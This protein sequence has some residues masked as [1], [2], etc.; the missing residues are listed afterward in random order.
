MIVF[1]LIFA[2]IAFL[3][4]KG[5]WRNISCASP[6]PQDNGPIGYPT[7]WSALDKRQVIRLL[8]GG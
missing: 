7:R 1:L 8:E 2:P 6:P 5:L 4:R 3:A